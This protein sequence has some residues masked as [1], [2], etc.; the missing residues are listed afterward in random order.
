M[1]FNYLEFFSTCDNNILYNFL[2]EKRLIPDS[3]SCRSCNGEMNL[4]KSKRTCIGLSWRCM[5]YSCVK[6]QTTI[7]VFN[8]SFF[9]DSKLDIRKTLR[10]IYYL[11]CG[12]VIADITK[13]TLIKK[14]CIIG[15]KKKINEIINNYWILNPIR[16][17]GYNNI[18][19]I[20]ELKLNFN[21]KSHRGRSP[22]EA[23]WA[24]TI[25]DTT[26][27]PSK[28]FV[29]IVEDRSASTL[30]PIIE[31]VVRSGSIIHTD[32][33]PS[34]S[35]LSEANNYSHGTVCHKYNF[36][37]PE[38][39][40]HTQNVE[41]FNNKIKYEIKKRKGIQKNQ[42]NDFL[43]YFLFLDHFKN[44]AFEKILTLMKYDL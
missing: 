32:E 23:V 26:I 14:K 12:T 20:D 5:N 6:Y 13:F 35:R 15:I 28:G 24:M 30:I 27:K 38:N 29:Q 44:E 33:W 19:Q 10:I 25:V 40:V 22:Q 41:S 21:V 42:R 9:S 11:C 37:N 8:K 43:N 39:F 1:V 17:G 36:I 31:R 3:M 16:L 7:S 2:I 18:V 4:N 34:Y